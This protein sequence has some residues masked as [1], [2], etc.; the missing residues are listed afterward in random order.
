MRRLAHILALV[1]VADAFPEALPEQP[2]YLNSRAI[3]LSFESASS[4]EIDR[5]D[6]WC[7]NDGGTTWNAPTVASTAPN[8]VRFDAP[9]DGTYGFYVALENKGGRS[10]EA[11]SPGCAPHVVVVV[12]T[13]P[14]T[15]QIHRAR[16]CTSPAGDTQIRLNVSLVD[17][18]LGEA[19]ARLFYRAGAGTAWQDGGP[20]IFADG[21][22]NWQPPPEISPP[23]DLRLI[24]TDLAGNR[25]SDEITGVTLASPSLGRS[26]PEAG[27][28]LAASDESRSALVEQVRASSVQPVTVDAVPV[29]TLGEQPKVGPTS[30]PAPEAEMRAQQLREQAARYLAEGRLPLA[31]ARFSEALKLAPDDPDLQVGLGSVFLRTRQ[32]DEAARRFRGALDACPDHLKAIEGLALVAISQNRYPQAR[33]YLRQLLELSPESGEHWLHYGD[34]EYRLGNVAEARAA[35]EKLLDFEPADDVLREKAQRRLTAFAQT[36]VDAE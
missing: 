9:Q 3:I 28:D 35:W 1:L 15:L 12:D 23:C 7:S 25:A 22:I 36:R 33:S 20:V 13:A 17:E 11:P 27:M 10:A 5:V 31:S 14:P 21:I 26:P 18:N 19:G 32:Y 29:V 34:I 4:A 6:L 30:Q 16:E 8:A 2:H 24:V